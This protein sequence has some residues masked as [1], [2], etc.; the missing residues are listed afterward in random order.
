MNAGPFTVGLAAA[1][2]ASASGFDATEQVGWFIF[3]SAIV[4]MALVYGLRNSSNWPV[5]KGLLPPLIV[6]DLVLALAL[7]F[8][9]I[10][11]FPLR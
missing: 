10:A 3:T 8:P 2:G 7:F 6:V 11:L 5:A 9:S 1:V 4:G